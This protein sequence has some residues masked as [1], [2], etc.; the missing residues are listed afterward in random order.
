V[1]STADWFARHHPVLVPEG[2]GEKVKHGGLA[3]RIAHL[4]PKQDGKGLDRDQEI[5]PGWEPLTAIGRE[6]SGGHQVMHRGMIVH[7]AS[8]GVQDPD[9]ADLAADKPGIS[10]E[11]LEGLG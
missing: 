1:R 10:G 9:H 2:V 5:F 4:G 11:D 6:S 8:P 3:Q 7:G